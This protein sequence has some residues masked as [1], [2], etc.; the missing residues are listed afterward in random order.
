M[1]TESVP[2]TEPPRKP[3]AELGRSYIESTGLLDTIQG[4]V[5][6]SVAGCSHRKSIGVIASRSGSLTVKLGVKLAP[7][8][9]VWL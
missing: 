6:A 7:E 2:A 4:E 5:T 3:T 8:L 9:T 1:V